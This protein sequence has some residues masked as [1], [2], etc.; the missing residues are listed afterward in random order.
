MTR[1]IAS[2]MSLASCLIFAQIITSST[3]FAGKET[4]GD[5]NFAPRSS[6][7]QDTPSTPPSQRKASKPES[8]STPRRLILGVIQGTPSSPRSLILNVVAAAHQFNPLLL[9]PSLTQPLPPTLVSTGTQTDDMSPASSSLENTDA[10]VQTSSA[11]VITDE[12]ILTSSISEESVSSP[13]FLPQSSPPIE[14]RAAS[15]SSLGSKIQSILARTPRIGCQ[16]DLFTI[17]LGCSHFKLSDGEVI[18]YR[19]IEERNGLP[20]GAYKRILERGV[21]PKMSHLQQ[22]LFHIIAYDLNAFG[23]G[24]FD[25]ALDLSANEELQL[26]FLNAIIHG[27]TV[28]SLTTD[29]AITA[30]I[31]HLIGIIISQWTPTPSTAGHEAAQAPS[32]SAFTL[33]E[34]AQRSLNGRGSFFNFLK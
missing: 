20:H 16:L 34:L 5:E 7:V 3:G 26:L 6:H 1:H 8:P 17:F 25:D 21:F 14:R 12:E 18:N 9:P 27:V 23:I 28:E 33:E 13:F 30:H 19:A 4:V 31:E 10:E 32:A 2:R 24:S 11:S 22:S 29:A 15:A